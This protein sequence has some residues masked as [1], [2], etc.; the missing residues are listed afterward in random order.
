MRMILIWSQF[1]S[2]YRI[3][4]IHTHHSNNNNNNNNNNN[5]NERD[6]VIFKWPNIYIFFENTGTHWIRLNFSRIK[7]NPSVRLTV[8][9]STCPS[10]PQHLTS[11]DRR[12]NSKWIFLEVYWLQQIIN[13]S[14]EASLSALVKSVIYRFSQ[15]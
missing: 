4:F 2:S 9:L 10:S 13:L 1:H 8:L 7:K 3:Y 15:G 12:L 14:T 11:T 5:D 6:A